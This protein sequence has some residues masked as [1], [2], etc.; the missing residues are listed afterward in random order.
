M[1]REERDC[2]VS[3]KSSGNES[4]DG[5]VNAFDDRVKLWVEEGI[6][7]C[8]LKAVEEPLDDCEGTIE[9]DRA[10]NQSPEAFC[11]ESEIEK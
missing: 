9:T 8:A 10:E 7:R 3:Y 4:Q 2:G 6:K 1:K 11:G 5:I